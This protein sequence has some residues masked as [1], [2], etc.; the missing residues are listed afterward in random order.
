LTV[1]IFPTKPSIRPNV[2]VTTN[3]DNLVGSAT[4]TAKQLM[5][6]GMAKGGEPEKIYKI[7][8]YAEAKSIFRGGD[9]L[10]AIEVALTPNSFSHSGTIYAERVGKATQAT[11]TNK[12]LTFKS[13]AFSIDAN[14]IQLALAKNTLNDTYNLTVNFDIDKYHKT[15]TNLGNI[16]GI[17]YTGSQAYTDVTVETDSIKDSDGSQHTNQATKIILRAGADKASA[18]VVKEFSLIQGMYTKISEV[19]SSINDIEGFN[20]TYFYTGN[21]NIETKYLDA[22]DKKELST[23]SSSPTYLT[24]LG[25]DILNAI[26]YEN[27]E[28]VTVEYDPAKGEPEPFDLTTLTGGTSSEIPPASW[29]KEIQNFST[30]SGTYIVP[31]TSDTTIQA[32]ALAFCIDRNREADPKA[33]IVGGG[34]NDSI[35][36]TIQR[37]SLL[38]SK[39]AR[40]GVVGCSATRL[41]NNGSVQDLP[42]YIIAAMIGGLATGLNIGESITFKQLDL[43]DVDQKYT[44]DQLDLLDNSG[45][46]GI[47][48]VRNRSSQIFRI[49][50]DIT[51]AKPIS[52]DPVETELGTGE[53]VDHLVVSLRSN[54][55]DEYIGTGTSLGVAGD[56]KAS[57]I[58]FLQQEQN[59]NIIVD[60]SESDIHVNV[61]GEVVLIQIVCVLARTLKTIHV[62]LS[63]VDEQITA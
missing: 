29:A 12:G 5:L 52:T 50:N 20:A 34:I 18:T 2:D 61:N 10:D 37:A 1:K 17:Y 57:I 19:I 42:A 53:E 14:T 28:A 6:I 54:L 41:M 13:K 7:N 39:D 33:M 11:F 47:E 3:T 45:V 8:T 9:L 21:K 60:Y 58:S 43:V 22:V 27:D 55:E 56:I 35:Q 24:S 16:M 4:D 15:Y 36:S 23:S 62:S 31:L 40:V 25:G 26:A 30:V 51:T 46:F 49:T 38:R 63:F 32:E 59:D 44:K 48:F